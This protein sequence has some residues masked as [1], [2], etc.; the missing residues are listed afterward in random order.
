MFTQAINQ[1]IDSVQDAKET[2]VNTYFTNEAVKDTALAYVG[3]QRAFA[4]DV[5]SSTQAFVDANADAARNVL[6]V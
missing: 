3:A 6:K 2:F 1:M 5:V 4:K